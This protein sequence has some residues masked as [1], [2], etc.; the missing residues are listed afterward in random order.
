MDDKLKGEITSSLLTLTPV[1]LDLIQRQ[2]EMQH[3]TEDYQL[4][5]MKQAYKEA[6]T[7]AGRSEI[8]DSMEPTDWLELCD[9]YARLVE[10]EKNKLGYRIV[11][12][13]FASGNMGLP[14]DQISSSMQRLFEFA[15]EDRLEP[16]E[17]YR[18]FETIHP[19]Q[20][21]NGRVGHLLWAIAE[22][23]RTGKWPDD[24]P[25]DVFGVEVQS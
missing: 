18:E 15:S 17:L 3:A 16:L 22:Q 19:Y 21:G 11:P 14:P 9:H 13:R 23:G 10:P 25:P 2:C 20:D 6:K 1:D 8:I 4:A 7:L 12:V 5:G 24:L